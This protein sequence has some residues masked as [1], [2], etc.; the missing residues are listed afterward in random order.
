MFKNIIVVASMIFCFCGEGMFVADENVSAM[1]D[2]V[3]RV[4]TSKE[5]RPEQVI[6]KIFN[7]YSRYEKIYE[8]WRVAGST[9]LIDVKQQ[10]LSTLMN[11]VRSKDTSKTI[12]YNLANALLISQTEEGK[13][14]KM[15]N[16]FDAEAISYA[17]ACLREEKSSDS[18]QLLEE[19][20]PLL[21]KTPLNGLI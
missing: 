10:L 9:N 14:K 3:V 6:L 8:I 1:R 15:K 18:L 7:S 5:K 13:F 12:N 2:E 21:S 20:K 19:T 11:E 16:G 17:I 4:V